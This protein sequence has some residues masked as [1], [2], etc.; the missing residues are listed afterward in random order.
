MYKKSILI[1]GLLMLGV[2][3]CKAQDVENLLL[4]NYRPQSIY[5]IP[6]TKVSKAK[7]PIIDMQSNP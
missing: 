7:Y 4:K 5:K 6:I 1:I 3:L 2:C